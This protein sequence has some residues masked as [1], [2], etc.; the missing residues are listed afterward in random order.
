MAKAPAKKQ[1]TEL[2]DIKSGEI[3]D[4][5]VLAG[6][7]EDA[8]DRQSF[9]IDYL[10]VP[11][12]GLTQDL[13]PQIKPEKPEYIA[14]ATIGMMFNTV[15]QELY[16]QGFTFIP[17]FHF[18]ATNAWRPRKQGGGLVRSNI[19][20]AECQDFE[21]DGI[22]SWRTTM[23][24]PRGEASDPPIAVEVHEVGSWAGLIVSGE[25][26]SEPAIIDFP[27]TKAKVGRQMNTIID[28]TEMPRADGSKFVPAAYYHRFDVVPVMDKNDS[29]D[30][31]NYKITHMGFN[32]DAAL[33]AKGKDLR[34]KM[35][36]GAAVASEDVAD[37]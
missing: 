35:T 1:N 10:I 23:P 16:P 26:K 31:Y 30:F 21:P 2:V 32:Q 37:I 7:E 8:G 27:S 25:G 11:R 6:M 24:D 17:S 29:G 13:S 4:P 33:I 3:I 36:S 22:K 12:V 9:G 20:P 15:T 5:S 28:M 18:V 19:D 14:G 34:Q